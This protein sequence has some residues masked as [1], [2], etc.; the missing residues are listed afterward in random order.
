MAMANLVSDI[1]A[2]RVWNI[3]TFIVA[4]ARHG[5]CEAGVIYRS[6]ENWASEN[7]A[8]W[9][10]LGV[11]QGNARGERF[12]D[13]ADFVQTRLREGVQFGEQ[14]NTLRVMVKFLAGGTLEQYLAL[15]PR[16]RPEQLS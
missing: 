3:S 8:Q 10:R 14:T 15:I 13:K 5:T 9:L 6:L 16:D 7:G 11:V 1:L 2:P 4:T 12:W